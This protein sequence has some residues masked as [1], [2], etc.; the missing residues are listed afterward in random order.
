MT[1]TRNIACT[2]LLLLAGLSAVKA[3][4]LLP[5]AYLI[6]SSSESGH[7]EDLNPKM[8]GYT[9]GFVLGGGMQ[10]RHFS[11]DARF[12]RDIANSNE[13]DNRLYF[14]TV[15]LGLG[16]TFKHHRFCLFGSWP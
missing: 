13:L 14:N 3:Q 2:T 1:F 5:S 10:F 7:I 12:N 8:N 6:T 4:R 15:Q 16:Y 9:L 11:V